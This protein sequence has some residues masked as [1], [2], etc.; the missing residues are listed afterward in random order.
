MPL[1]S[2]MQMIRQ[3]KQVLF[4]AQ[5]QQKLFSSSQPCSTHIHTHDT[6]ITHT[7]ENVDCPEA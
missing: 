2:R 7:W 5:E 3:Q 4:T 6:H 1:C